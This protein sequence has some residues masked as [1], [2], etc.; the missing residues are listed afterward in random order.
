MGKKM[1]VFKNTDEYIENQSEEAQVILT[2]LLTLIT[3]TAPETR[4]I[5]KSKVSQFTLVPD[6]NRKFRL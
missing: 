4:E 2:E 1:S 6:K 3:K 5:P